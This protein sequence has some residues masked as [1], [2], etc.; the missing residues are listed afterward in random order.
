MKK[1]LISLAMAV[2]AFIL[3]ASH[4]NHGLHDSS[5]PA[6]PGM[7]L[8]EPL[9]ILQGS[10]LFDN[11]CKHGPLLF[12]QSVVEEVFGSKEYLPDH[13][14]LGRLF[15]ILAHEGTSWMFTGAEGAGINVTAARLGSCFAFALMVWLLFEFAGRR[16]DLKTAVVAAIALMIMPRVVGHARLA[17]LETTTTLA[18]LVACVPLWAWWTKEKPP[19]SW[20]CLVSGLLWGMLMLTKVQGVLLPPVVVVWSFL[21][22]RHL[23]IRP[24]ALWGLTGVAIFFF[25][26]PWLWLDPVENTLQYLGQATE[27]P[28][29]YVWYFGERFAD[30]AVPWHYPLVMFALTVPTCVFAL[31]VLRLWKRKLDGVEQ[32]ALATLLWPLILFSV[33]GTP[34]YDGTRLFL[35][36]MP[37]VA[38]LS[39]RG[40]LLMTESVAAARVKWCWLL[41]GIA[42]LLSVPDV[43]QPFGTDSY[44]WLAGRAAGAERL[45]MEASYWADGMNGDFWEQVPEGSRIYVAP[46]SHQVQLT[47]LQN[48]VPAVTRRNLKLQPF[49]YEPEKQ[50]G[51]ILLIHR[52][53]DLPVAL[54]SVPDGAKV[55]AEA[56]FHG[57]VL[58]RLI[59]TTDATWPKIP[60]W[61]NDI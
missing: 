10:Y 32:L 61:P 37:A 35:I 9:Y 13:P 50:R 54:R 28:T 52:L 12:T 1:N 51:Y 40:L 36:I 38:L 57:V 17:A 30:K 7:T 43:V 44:S 2:F 49:L 34:V 41:A 26:W 45:G 53:A 59:D 27:R 6:G 25:G 24:L 46:V 14:P 33:P 29:L 31:F 47:A 21:K 22:F 58:C 18:W 3:A 48:F 60:P 42:S 55:V 56:R 15:L 4:I 16:Y 20:Q 19:T 8:D 5:L 11:F 39:A 23:A